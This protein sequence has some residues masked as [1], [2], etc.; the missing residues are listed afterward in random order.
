MVLDTRYM[1]LLFIRIMNV[2]FYNSFF[3]LSN[4]SFRAGTL[5]RSCR[6]RR[7]QP[8]QVPK[9]PQAQLHCHSAVAQCRCCSQ[10]PLHRRRYHQSSPPSQHPVPRQSSSASGLVGLPPSFPCRRRGHFL[11]SW[12]QACDR[13]A[14]FLLRGGQAS[15]IVNR[16]RRVRS[17]LRPPARAGPCAGCSCGRCDGLHL[18]SSVGRRHRCCQ[19]GRTCSCWASRCGRRGSRGLRPLVRDGRSQMIVV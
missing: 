13:R 2:Y 19:C 6:Y 15:A 18:P 8:L 3:G 11:L 7:R 12:L 17:G 5:T 14:L 16:V 4:P 1:R 9:W 10:Q